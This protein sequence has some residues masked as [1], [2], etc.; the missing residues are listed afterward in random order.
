MRCLHRGS[1][2][3]SVQLQVNREVISAQFR[4]LIAYTL[5]IHHAQTT[6]EIIIKS[7]VLLTLN[8]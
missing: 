5:T 6:F 7:L 1:A 8:I 2:S 4:S 3:V